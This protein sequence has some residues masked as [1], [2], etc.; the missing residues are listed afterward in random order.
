MKEAGWLAGLGIVIG[1]LC[2]IGAAT[3]MRGLLFGVRSWDV[4]TLAT[5]CAV[6]AISAL[7]A[8]YVPARR[9]A[10]VDPMVA[11]RYE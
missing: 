5:V 4:V 10:K 2:S 1:V 9:A 7:V 8:S 6:L 3:L 11:L